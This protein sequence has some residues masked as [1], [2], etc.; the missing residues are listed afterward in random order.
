MLLGRAFI[1]A[2]CITLGTALLPTAASAGVQ[3]KVDI[4]SQTMDVYMNG[5]LVHS[6]WPISSAKGGAYTPRGSFDVQSL[7]KHHRSSRYNG[8]PMPHAVF[9][10]GHY[11]IHGTYKEK[12]LGR[13][14]SH[15]CVRLS[16]VNA[17]KLFALVQQVGEKKVS[18][19]IKN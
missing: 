13:P 18:I 8:A 1:T 4:S 10:R 11:A 17:R 7:S 15:G 12:E 6:N 16:R 2:L 5:K 19:T 9:F 3:V 14:A